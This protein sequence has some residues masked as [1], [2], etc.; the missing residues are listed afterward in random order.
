MMNRMM[1]VKARRAR[2]NYMRKIHQIF[3]KYWPEM[4][5]CRAKENP[6][7][8][9]LAARRRDDGTYIQVEIKYE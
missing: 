6:L 1:S 3:M 4:F 8:A 7:F 2:P 9:K 5:A